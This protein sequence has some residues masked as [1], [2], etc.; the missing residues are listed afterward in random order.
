MARR[1][2]REGRLFGFN[3]DDLDITRR[4]IKANGDFAGL[5]ETDL[6]INFN[7]RAK[8]KSLYFSID[9]DAFNGRQVQSWSFSNYKKYSKAITKPKYED[10]YSKAVNDLSSGTSDGFQSGV[11]GLE[12]MPGIED[13]SIQ[14][15]MLDGSASYFWT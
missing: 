10:L 11:D 2:E 6:I 7:K 1:L 12:R 15:L 4:S 9:Y 14:M 8:I 5:G 13:V 3:F